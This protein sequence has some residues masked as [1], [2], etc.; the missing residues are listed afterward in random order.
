VTWSLRHHREVSGY[1]FQHTS[2]SLAKEPLFSHSLPKKILPDLSINLRQY[3]FHFFG[4]RNSNS[5]LQSKVRQ[6]CVQP[7]T[8]RTTSLYLCPPVTGWLIVSCTPR[9]RVPFPS[10]STTRGLW[11]GYSNRPPHGDWLLPYN[12]NYKRHNGHLGHTGPVSPSRCLL[13]VWRTSREVLDREN[14][15][16]SKN[17]GSLTWLPVFSLLSLFWNK[18]Y[19]EE[20]IAYFPWYDKGYI[21][22]DASNNSSIVACVFVTAVTFLPS[23]DKGIFTEPFL[24]TIGGYTHRQQRDLISL[25]YFFKIR[26]VGW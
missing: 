4:F 26:K 21:E 25:L 13:K 20:L 19:W 18:K 16:Q 7:P 12:R 11:W 23:N 15:K 5:V 10:P 2:S 22:N 8:W 1:Y 3:G 14:P 17:S 9:H 6:P 24:T